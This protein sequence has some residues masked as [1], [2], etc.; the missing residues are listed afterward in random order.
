MFTFREKSFGEPVA[1]ILVEDEDINQHDGSSAV[2]VPV[3][4][5]IS[6]ITRTS[7]GSKKK[8]KEVQSPYPVSRPLGKRR[9]SDDD[10]RAAQSTLERKRKLPDDIIE[11]TSESEADMDDSR[12]EKHHNSPD[13]DRLNPEPQAVTPQPVIMS[14]SPVSPKKVQKKKS[15]SS[16]TAPAR[17]SPV[18][19]RSTK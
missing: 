8:G 3:S 10:V 16:K 4:P 6:R 14:P 11:L 7:A 9:A 18:K 13:I 15:A 12:T 2:D 1:P 17:K 19:T 5:T